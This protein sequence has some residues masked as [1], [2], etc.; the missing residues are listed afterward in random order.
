MMNIIYI[1]LATCYVLFDLL[2]QSFDSLPID[3][4]MSGMTFA[5][6]HKH[7]PQKKNKLQ[8]SERSSI[9]SRH[10]AELL[11]WCHQRYVGVE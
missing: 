6:V 9:T 3:T 11:E 7:A 5:H 4:Q 1:I 8:T 2:L 10:L